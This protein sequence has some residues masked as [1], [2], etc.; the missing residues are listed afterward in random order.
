MNNAIT[1]QKQE[2]RRTVRKKAPAISLEERE[3]LSELA[4]A[5]LRDWDVWRNAKTVLLYAALP[6]EMDVWPLALDGIA[7]GKTVALPKFMPQTGAYAAY[8]IKNAKSDCA[9]GN[10]GILEPVAGCAQIELGRL[11]LVVVPGIAFNASGWRLG[12]G[13]GF[14]DRLLAGA[15]G[16]KC[17]VAF[18]WQ[19]VESVPVE[20]HD[21]RLDCVLTPLGWLKTASNA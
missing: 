16:T 8:Q 12:R 21:A 1:Q 18:D 15:K 5:W 13:R 2:L 14:Y 19:I 20:P 7:Q 9:P 11:D 3:R 4:C 10:Y 6:D 17:G